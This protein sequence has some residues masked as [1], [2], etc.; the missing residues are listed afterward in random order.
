VAQKLTYDTVNK[1]FIL[2]SGVTS[3]DIKVDL[4]SDAKEDWKDDASLTKFRFPLNAIGGQDLGGGQK[5]SSYITLLYGWKIRP[6]EDNHTL[7]VTGNVIT[8]DA[9]SP[10][11]PTIGNYNV[12][13]YSQV[14]SNSLTEGSVWSDSEK[15]SVIKTAKLAKILSIIK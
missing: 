6:H 10:F 13:I 8:S 7:T 12:T 4:Y 11:V 5:I 3:I 2:N 15:E 9:S 14:S 1:L